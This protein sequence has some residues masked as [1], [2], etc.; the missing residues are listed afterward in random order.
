MPADRHQGHTQHTHH[1][2]QARLCQ[3]TTDR[4]QPFPHA[5]RRRRG[6]CQHSQSGRAQ[7]LRDNSQLALSSSRLLLATHSP[8]PMGENESKVMVCSDRIS[9]EKIG[10]FQH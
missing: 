3:D 2:H 9:I 5:A 8:L 1:G 7:T 10:M 4:R 6:G